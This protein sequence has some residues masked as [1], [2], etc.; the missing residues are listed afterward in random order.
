MFRCSGEGD[1]G[2]FIGEWW[3]RLRQ[4]SIRYGLLVVQ[5]GAILS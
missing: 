2:G 4:L 1:H 3:S 5:S